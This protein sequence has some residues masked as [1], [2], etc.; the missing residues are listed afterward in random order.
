M[1]DA[2]SDVLEAIRLRG[3]GVSRG[4]GLRAHVAYAQGARLVHLVGHGPVELDLP[5][6]SAA[7]RLGPGDMAVMARGQEHVVSSAS[8]ASWLTCHFD[9]EVT[10][11]DRFL[12]V[13]PPCIVVRADQTTGAWLPLSYDLLLM[14]LD[15]RR[16]GSRVMVSRILDLLFVHTLR[17]WASQ[18]DVQPGW[19][20]GALDPAVGPVLAALH[21]T[22]GQS[23]SVDGMARLAGLSRSAFAGR[24]TAR[25]GQSPAAYLA[26]RRLDHAADLL[27]S[28][29]ESVHRI[30]AAVGYTSQ[31]AFSRAFHRRFGAS[32]QQWRSSRRQAE[33]GAWGADR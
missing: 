1:A 8:D 5:G 22:L 16:P 28:S 27:A 33:P 7:V 23:W 4:E 21:R 12:H 10:L 14:E 9:V 24:F 11:A 20:T 25:V 6:A 26:E 29:V 13:L 2:L 15:G 19:L 18:G 31:A 30:G 17:A 3:A 32:P